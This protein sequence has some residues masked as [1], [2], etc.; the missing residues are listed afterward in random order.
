M[1]NSPCISVTLACLSIFRPPGVC[2]KILDRA[3]M[4]Y[5]GGQKVQINQSR[6]SDTKLNLNA[7]YTFEKPITHLKQLIVVKSSVT[8][9]GSAT[10]ITYDYSHDKDEVQIKLFSNKS[11]VT[12]SGNAT[13]TK[14]WYSQLTSEHF[15]GEKALGNEVFRPKS[16][17][18][19]SGSGTLTTKWYSQKTSEH[20]PGEKAL[21]NELF[22]QK[23]SVTF[24]SSSTLR[25]GVPP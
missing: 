6:E 25:K 17:V 20:F 16:S 3:N 19:L 9:S 12:L 4:Q 1:Y 22:R 5:K 7:T 11:S 21:R 13:L 8:L 15:P 2:N 24:K 10:L 18:T 23:S 14:Q